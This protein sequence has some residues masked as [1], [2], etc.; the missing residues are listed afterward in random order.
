MD[1]SLQTKL[2]IYTM[3]GQT[4]RQWPQGTRYFPVLDLPNSVYLLVMD[5]FRPQKLVIQH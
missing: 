3:Q 2:S 1:P 4:V 5:G